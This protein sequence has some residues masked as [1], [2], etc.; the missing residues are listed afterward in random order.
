MQFQDLR[1]S[2]LDLKLT[3]EMFRRE[4]ID[5]RF[6]FQSWSWIHFMFWIVLVY[7]FIF[8]LNR[9]L[10]LKE[11]SGQMFMNKW[12][13][14]ASYNFFLLDIRKNVSSIVFISVI[15]SAD[16]MTMKLL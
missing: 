2:E 8:F 6:E 16:L 13:V 9:F 7:I 10:H 1:E 14:E 5:S 15:S 11:L 3:L 12:I 4:S